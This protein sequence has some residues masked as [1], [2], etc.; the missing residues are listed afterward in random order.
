MVDMTVIATLV[1][2]VYIFASGFRFANRTAA[3]SGLAVTLI[4]IVFSAL[5]TADSA[6]IFSFELKVLGGCLLVALVGW[7]IF[8]RC[9]AHR[10]TQPS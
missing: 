5:P 7:I 1:P 6:S 3:V 4:A 9:S 8:R 2:F 10:L